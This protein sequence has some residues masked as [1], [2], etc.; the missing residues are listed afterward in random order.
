MPTTLCSFHVNG[1]PFRSNFI[2]RFQI[3]QVSC[4]LSL[5]FSFHFS[6]RRLRNHLTCYCF[7][8]NTKR[9]ITRETTNITI[10]KA[11]YEALEFHELQQQATLAL[12]FRV[13]RPNVRDYGLGIS[14]I[15]KICP[16]FCPDFRPSRTGKM[17][18]KNGPI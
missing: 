7:T 17:F 14:G 11:P 9:Q 18:M 2:N 5:N 16:N 6:S 15:L 4:E 12:R 10:E 13:F 3:L 1:C 8:I